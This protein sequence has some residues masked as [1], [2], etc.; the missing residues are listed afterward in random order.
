MIHLILGGARSGKSAFAQNSVVQLQNETG[1]AVSYVATATAIDDEMQNR[2]ERHQADRPS[3]WHLVEVPLELS[4]F[5]RQAQGPQ[6]QQGILLIDCLT[7][8]LNNQLY[9]FPEQD[10]TALF[11]QLSDSLENCNSDVFLVANEVGLGVIPTGELS[12]KFV[13]QAGWLNQ[14]IAAIADKVTF[15]SAGLPLSLKS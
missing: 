13:D 15:V 7:L 8:W 3:P 12:R 11:E 14:K 4:E 5:L 2:I 1:L 10:F 6:Q 9:H